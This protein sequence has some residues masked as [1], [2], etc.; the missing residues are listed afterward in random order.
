[1]IAFISVIISVLALNFSFLVFLDSRNR[2]RRDIFLKIH[3]L[4]ISDDLQRGRYILFQ[5]ITDEESIERLTD[6]EWQ[7]VNRALSTFNALGLYMANRYVKEQDV[8]DTWAHNICT[9]WKAAKPF[10]SYRERLQGYPAWIYFAVLADKAQ[11][12]LGHKGLDTDLRI[13]RRN[14]DVSSARSSINHEPQ[15]EHEIT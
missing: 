5:K 15:Q 6:R 11:Q 1:V 9:A 12:Y 4:L 3:E 10:I 8:M 2:D 14:K 7:D 13:Y